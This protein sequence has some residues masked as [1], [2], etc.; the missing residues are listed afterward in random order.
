LAPHHDGAIHHAP[1]L[2][3]LGALAHEVGVTDVLLDPRP[4]DGVL[5]RHQRVDRHVLDRRLV[6]PLVDR[7]APD[8]LLVPLAR[9]EPQRHRHLPARRGEGVQ[10]RQRH[11]RRPRRPLPLVDPLAELHPA[12]TTQPGMSP[13][14]SG[15]RPC[16]FASATSSSTSLSSSSR[17]FTP[18]LSTPAIP[19]PPAP[20]ALMISS[21]SVAIRQT[22]ESSGAW[23]SSAQ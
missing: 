6:D 12:E 11:L 18:N 2:L 7:R 21:C 20:A 5:D 22:S 16:A 1:V 23:E 3:V 19:E 8:D 13:R 14:T 17:A 4:V 10:E 15:P 9:D